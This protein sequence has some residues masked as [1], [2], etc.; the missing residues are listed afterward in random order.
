[1]GLP[2][3]SRSGLKACDM[4]FSGHVQETWE[5]AAGGPWGV[6]GGPERSAARRLPGATMAMRGDVQKA[7]AVHRRRPVPGRVPSPEARAGW[8]L[9]EKPAAWRGR[10]SLPFP[11]CNVE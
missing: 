5:R 9:S 11:G 4:H 8:A 6:G 3:A 1:M 2:L 10:E 7:G